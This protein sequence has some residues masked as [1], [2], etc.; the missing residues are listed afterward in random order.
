MEDCRACQVREEAI[1]ELMREN[2]KLRMLLGL[3]N[4]AK[5][6]LEKRNKQL[7]R[8]SDDAF[9]AMCQSEPVTQADGYA[10]DDECQ[11]HTTVEKVSDSQDGHISGLPCSTPQP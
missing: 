11:C 6:M 2:D 10:G 9:A 3:K 1:D 5:S 4:A 8:E 7:Q